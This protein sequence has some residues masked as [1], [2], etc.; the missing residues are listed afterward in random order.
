MTSHGPSTSGSATSST[1]RR[2]SS[3][4]RTAFMSVSLGYGCG[5]SV[6][7]DVD[8]VGVD[9]YVYE[10][11]TIPVADFAEHAVE[12]LAAAHRV[13]PSADAF[14]QWRELRRRESCDSGIHFAQ[15]E[16]NVLCAIG[17]VVEQRDDDVGPVPHRRVELGEATQHDAAITAHQDDRPFRRGMGGTDSGRHA[18]TYVAIVE[19]RLVGTGL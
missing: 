10:D 13:A 17:A 11:R 12:V 15:G 1:L 9:L 4:I 8:A 14:C 6:M 5:R 16:L 18:E 19:R 3:A 2:R 7:A